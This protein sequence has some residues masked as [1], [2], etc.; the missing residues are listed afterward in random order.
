MTAT[1][2][3]VLVPV[4][5]GLDEVRACVESVRRHG[6][7]QP[8]ELLIIN[9]DSP[10]PEVVHYVESL[11]EMQ[12]PP[13]AP[14][15]TVLHNSSNLGFVATVNIGFE[16]SAGD[17]V[18]LNADTVVTDGWLDRMC[19]TARREPDVAT[20]TPLTNF[21]SICTVPTELIDAFDLAS[22]SPKIDECAAFIGDR[23]LGRLPEVITGVGFCMLVTR[24]ALDRC[25]PF[26]VETFG[27][28]YGEEVDFCLRATR[29]GFRHLVED[30]TFVYHRGAVSFG[31]ERVAGLERGSALIRDRYPWFK[32]SLRREQRERPLGL[33]FAALQLGLRERDERRPHVLHLLHSAPDALGGSE[34]HLSS[35]DRCTRI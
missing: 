5:R 22:G 35:A 8:F 2:V 25:G 4:Y 9:D 30:R 26:D 10:E 33:S 34:K 1:G 18:I 28:G 24:D 6:A 27:R 29:L 20:V 7:R 3:T 15:L 19:D 23:G 14:H 32:P 31:D 12:A 11:T 13:G 21:G 17:V 16:R